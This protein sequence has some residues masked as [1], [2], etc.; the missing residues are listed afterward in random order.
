MSLTFLIHFV[1]TSRT[2]KHLWD[3][4]TPQTIL[5][6]VHYTEERVFLGPNKQKN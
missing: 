3:I 5:E 4:Y 6:D 2:G 1:N